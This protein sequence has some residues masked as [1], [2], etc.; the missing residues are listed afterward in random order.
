MPANPTTPLPLSVIHLLMVIASAIVA[1][2]FTIGEAIAG[3]MDPAVLTLLRFVLASLL[4]APYIAVRH[5]FSLP[6]RPA[7][8]GYAMISGCIVGFF[9]CMFESLRTTSAL[10]TSAI[11]TLVPAIS[12]FYGRILIK[13][14]LGGWRIT[15]L[16]VGMIGA[17]WVIFRGDWQRFIAL[18]LNSGDLVFF[19]GCFLMAFYT[20]L[21]KRFYRHE[22]MEMMTFW[23][24]VTGCAWLTLASF[25][26]LPE[27]D[28]QGTP[29][30]VWLGILYLA[31]FSTI[32]T[33]FL[34]QYA[35]LFLG[36]TRVM[37]YSYLYPAFVLIL[38]W[39]LGHGLPPASTLPGVFIVLAATVIVQTGVTE[40]QSPPLTSAK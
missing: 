13:E 8:I 11:F 40:T 22:S 38:D 10:N 34:S 27:T 26:K 36:P 17:L 33:F 31:V 32:I 5:G 7:L 21:V 19:A 4:F 20:P 2:T 16:V 37:A 6:S 30:S 15:A 23:I 24:L 14:R 12:G 9:W 29:L 1:A 35:T 39:I 3:S 18:D 25:G 28:W